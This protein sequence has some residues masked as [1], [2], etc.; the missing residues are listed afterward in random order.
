MQEEVRIGTRKSPLALAQAED[1]KRRLI[2]AHPGVPADA[3]IIVPMMTTG[4]QVQ[5]RTLL[6]LGGKGLFTKEIEDQLLDGGIDLAVHSS[7][8]MPTRLPEG[9]D[10]PVFIEREDP[11]DA[12]LCLSAGSIEELPEGAVVGTASLRR[13]AQVL[14]LRPDLKVVPFRGNVG[15]R[16]RKLEDGVVD[17]TLLA[18]AGLNRLGQTDAATCILPVDQMLPA[19]AQ[20]AVGIE[21]RTGDSR[22]LE[23][24]APL[25]HEE[26]GI[27]VRAER[28]L[29][30]ALD[31]S[32]RTP[33]AA[34]SHLGGGELHLRGRLLSPDGSQCF[35]ITDSG[36]PEDAVEIGRRAGEALR[37]MAGEDFFAALEQHM[38]SA[39]VR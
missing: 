9:L 21:T 3:F 15:T 16:R 7:K 18:L 10:F 2:E 28:A 35:E 17:A 4:D 11:R 37:T 31:G 38:A 24:L 30:D 20:G 32:C 26:T 33:I 19:P 12:F 13:G 34:L 8:D 5:D 1:V 25:H 27:A 6:E 14:R 36:A 23:L 22:I 29:L 39:E